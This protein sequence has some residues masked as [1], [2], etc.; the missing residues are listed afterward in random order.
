[1]VVSSKLLTVVTPAHQVPLTSS[2]SV[3][4]SS[5][6]RAV[7]VSLAKPTG[8]LRCAA[9]LAVEVTATTSLTFRRREDR[10]LTITTREECAEK[11]QGS[12]S[13]LIFWS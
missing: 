7:T 6:P 13:H 1:V 4:D 10:V 2:V 8:L 3:I 12:S 9:S 11:Y 5:I